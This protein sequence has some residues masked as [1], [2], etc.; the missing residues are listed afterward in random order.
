MP[1]VLVQ[2]SAAN[3]GTAPNNPGSKA[4]EPTLILIMKTPKNP[5]TKK[6]RPARSLAHL[7]PKLSPG[8]EPINRS[9]I[10]I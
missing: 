4:I 10:E 8:L 5:T 2:V 6:V 1:V 9:S 7:L 3:A